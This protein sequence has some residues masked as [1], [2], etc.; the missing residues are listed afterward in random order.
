MKIQL[1]LD[2]LPVLI[3]KKMQTFRHKKSNK[4]TS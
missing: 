3:N 2:L 4:K 1:Y